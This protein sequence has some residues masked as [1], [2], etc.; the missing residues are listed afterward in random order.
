MVD[1]DAV[2]KDEDFLEMIKIEHTLFALP[3]AFMGAIL[4]SIVMTNHLPGW[5]AIGWVILAR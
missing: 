4:G 5:A 1:L 3:F 2:E